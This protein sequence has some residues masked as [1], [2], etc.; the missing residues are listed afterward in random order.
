MDYGGYQPK[1]Q[2]PSIIDP[3]FLDWS[4]TKLFNIGEYV[5]G[6]YKEEVTFEETIKG[7]NDI[8]YNM[9]KHCSPIK[10]KPFTFNKSCLEGGNWFLGKYRWYPGLVRVQGTGES[11]PDYLALGVIIYDVTC[12][13]G[14][15]TRKDDFFLAYEY[16]NHSL[17]TIEAYK[18]CVKILPELIV[19]YVKYIIETV[20]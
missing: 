13:K 20:K 5:Q 17:E 2:V 19:A 16:M 1:E 18:K 8:L 14:R 12:I 10:M 7:V 6:I 15:I 11:V 3:K 4:K 9:C